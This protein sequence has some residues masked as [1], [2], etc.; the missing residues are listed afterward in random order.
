[1]IRHLRRQ[2]HDDELELIRKCMAAGDAGHAKALN[3]VEAGMSELEVYQHILQAATE[4]A[5]RPVILYGD[6]RATNRKTP[7]AA[8]LP[9]NYELR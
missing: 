3:I 9:T 1:M 6:F 8:G 2:K 7:K 4:E 5:E